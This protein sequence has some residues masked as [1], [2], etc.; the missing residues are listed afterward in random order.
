LERSCPGTWTRISTRSW[1][2]R[3]SDEALSVISFAGGG[4]AHA[5]LSSGSPDGG[6][7]SLFWRGLP[8]QPAPPPVLPA[9][10]SPC[11]AVLPEMVRLLPAARVIWTRRGPG[12]L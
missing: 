3:H 4:P 9:D 7:P 8:T 12:L 6:Y 5:G 2:G 11:S 1:P 10:A